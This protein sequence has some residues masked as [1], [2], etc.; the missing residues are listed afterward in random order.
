VPLHTPTLSED[1]TAGCRVLPKVTA[2]KSR[3]T[4]ITLREEMSRNVNRV[5]PSN[6]LLRYTPWQGNHTPWPKPCPDIGHRGPLADRVPWQIREKQNTEVARRIP[7]PFPPPSL[8]TG[9][10]TQTN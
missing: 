3:S 8:R 1:R 5:F 7:N 6:L 2:K 4:A 9:A 10:A